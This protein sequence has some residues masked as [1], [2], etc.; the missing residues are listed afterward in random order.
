MATWDGHRIGEAVHANDAQNLLLRQSVRH[1][2]GWIKKIIITQAYLFMEG[3]DK[4][5]KKV[6]SALLQELKTENWT[7]GP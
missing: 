6:Y 1:I 2:S 4:L 3:K 5:K 7:Y